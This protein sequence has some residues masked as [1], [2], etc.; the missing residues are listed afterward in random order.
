MKGDPF[1]HFFDLGYVNHATHPPN[2]APRGR[3]DPF[4]TKTT[5]ESGEGKSFEEIGLEKMV[6]TRKF[7]FSLRSQL[8]WPAGKPMHVGA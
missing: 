2:V 4:S 7:H 5:K 6:G 8:T 3:M 1:R